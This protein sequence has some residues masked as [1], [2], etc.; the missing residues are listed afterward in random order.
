MDQM[1]VLPAEGACDLEEQDM[2]WRHYTWM[3]ALVLTGVLMAVFIP[4]GAQTDETLL[5]LH[6]AGS[7]FLDTSAPTSTTAKFKDSPGLNFNNGNP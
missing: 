5:F 6:T 2:K 4:L 1:G 7:D 3:I